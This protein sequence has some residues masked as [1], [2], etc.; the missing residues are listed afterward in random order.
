MKPI[1]TLLLFLV[2]SLCA[3]ET[4]STS[5]VVP[6]NSIFSSSASS[7]FISPREPKNY[8]LGDELARMQWYSAEHSLAAQVIQIE[9]KFEPI[10]VKRGDKWVV[11]IAQPLN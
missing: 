2:L 3:D 11:I 10:V 9:T 4:T 8:I 6:S 7:P 1:I 5:L